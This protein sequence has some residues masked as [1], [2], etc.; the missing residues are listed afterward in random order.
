LILAKFLRNEQPDQVCYDGKFSRIFF[1]SEIIVLTPK[2]ISSVE[3]GDAGVPA[4]E[5]RRQKKRTT[6]PSKL[7]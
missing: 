1:C 6:G 2:A 5:Q 4:T 7:N 3:Y